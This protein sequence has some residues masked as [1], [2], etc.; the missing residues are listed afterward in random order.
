MNAFRPLLAACFFCLVSIPFVHADQAWVE[1]NSPH[2]SVM[3]DGG[4]KRAR[5]VALRFE[6]M[7]MAF[8]VIFQ[9]VNVT[10]APLEIVAFRKSKEMKQYAPL[11][12][13]KPIEVAGFFLGDGGHGRTASNQDRQYIALDLSDEDNW[14]TVFHEYAHLLINSNVS[15]T[16][17][18]FDEGFAEYCSSLRVNKKEIDLGMARPDLLETLHQSGWLRLVDLFSVTHN[19]KIYNRD[20]RRSLLYA[21]SWITVHYFMSKGMMKQV[22]AYVRYS[23]DQHQPV[24]QAIRQA[25]GMEPQQLEKAISN[26]FRSGEAGYFKA[27]A[28]PGAENITF[29]SRPLNDLETRTV[30]ADLDFHARD[31]RARGIAAFQ[32]I[33]RE[34]PENVVA[35]RGLG[36]AALEKNEWEKAEEYF[37]RA[38]A[39]NSKDP[40]VHYLVAYGLSQKARA[41]GRP[42]DD[43]EAMK[44]ELNTAIALDPNYAD[45]YGLLGMTLAFTGEKE[46][47]IT[48]LKKAIALDP[49]NEWNYYN[50]AGVYIRARDFDNALRMVQQLQTSSNPQIALMAAQQA[51]SIQNYKQSLARL[52]QAAPDTDSVTVVYDSEEGPTEG[53]SGPPA[54]QQQVMTANAEPVLFMKGILN[55]V[56]CSQSPGAALSVTSAGKKWTMLAPDAKRLI[57]LGAD[58]LS[59]SW[60]NRRVA[61]NYRKTGASEGQLVSLELQ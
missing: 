6:Q 34:Q 35:N 8:G 40:Q 31:Y 59:C 13:G 54:A 9:K 39:S 30:L 57:V 16:P 28:P 52:Q 7:R 37:K 27:A 25:F 3:T 17:L 41:A 36:Y 60:K 32:E 33:L 55:S 42:P 47:A 49:R 19:A 2:F 44:K 23:Q 20:D 14:G 61:V 5:E 10:T 53:K 51:Q 12:Q 21:Q 1:V 24:P 15:T 11:Y 29:T 38:A 18:W 26:Y 46:N 58:S 56:D 45:A 43:L 4:E 22:A 50:L 48:I